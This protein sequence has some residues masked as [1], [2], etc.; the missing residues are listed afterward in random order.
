MLNVLYFISRLFQHPPKP[1]ITKAIS[2]RPLV[3]PSTPYHTFSMYLTF[4]IIN[5]HRSC[6][7]LDLK[8]HR[9][10]DTVFPKHWHP[11]PTP[12][13]YQWAE[14]HRCLV[15]LKA[16][17]SAL[18][19][20]FPFIHNKICLL[21]YPRAFC[22]MYALSYLITLC[23]IL[24]LNALFLLLP[25]PHPDST[26]VLQAE[27]GLA[28]YQQSIAHISYPVGINWTEPDRKCLSIHFL[29]RCKGQ[30]PRIKF[31]CLQTLWL[32]KD[33]ADSKE[34]PSFC[35]AVRLLPCRRRYFIGMHRSLESALH[36]PPYSS[37]VL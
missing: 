17:Q 35:L 19:E 3:F 11:P 10:R 26:T 24:W 34:Q 6:P 29:C 22:G 32:G 37:K 20:S 18:Y 36:F 23:L 15:F 2:P 1:I 12:S 31:I 33:L 27:T 4:N 5:L 30:A 13:S 16:S 9:G 21:L 8:L 7:W 14:A 28:N 25:T